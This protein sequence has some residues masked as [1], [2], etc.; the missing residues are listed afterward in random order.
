MR[1]SSKGDDPPV[2]REILDRS[3]SMKRP[4][5]FVSRIAW[6]ILLVISASCADPVPL[7]TRKCPC[8]DTEGYVCCEATNVCIQK[9]AA[10]G[11]GKADAG[12]DAPALGGSNG[13]GGIGG[14]NQGG[15][16]GSGTGG[17][18]GNVSASGGCSGSGTEI[19]TLDKATWKYL[20]DGSNQGT[21]WRQPSFDDSKWKTGVGLLGYGDPDIKTQVAPGHTTYYYRSTFNVSN[22]ACF[23]RVKLQYILDDGAVF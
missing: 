8:L 2:P 16:G 14:S 5:I 3:I 10:C 12:G 6:S 21:N 23:R 11:G 13:S 15:S 18:G 20:D 9:G 17:T 7:E 22:V 19:F 1:H 4:H